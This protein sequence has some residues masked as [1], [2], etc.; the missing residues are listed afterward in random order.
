MDLSVFCAMEIIFSSLF[1]SV[2]R[3][4]TKITCCLY[5]ESKGAGIA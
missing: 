5:R 4:I 2:D 1:G 3:V